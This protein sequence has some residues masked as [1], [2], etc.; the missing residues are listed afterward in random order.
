MNEIEQLWEKK[1]PLYNHNPE[2]FKGNGF[3]SWFTGHWVSFHRGPKPPE[4]LDD[5][6]YW[7]CGEIVR[8]WSGKRWEI[9][10][11]LKEKQHSP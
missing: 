2:W 5:H 3:Q 8:K 7:I 1:D 6:T 11:R 9:T 4:A 10:G